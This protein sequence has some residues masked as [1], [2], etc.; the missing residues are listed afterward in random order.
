MKVQNIWINMQGKTRDATWKFCFHRSKQRN[1][2]KRVQRGEHLARQIVT[3]HRLSPSTSQHGHLLAYL[4]MGWIAGGEQ[5]KRSCSCHC[6]PQLG[7]LRSA[8]PAHNCPAT[9]ATIQGRADIVTGERRNRPQPAD[10]TESSL[11]TLCPVSL[12]ISSKHQYQ[13]VPQS[14]KIVVF[15]TFQDA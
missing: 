6:T 9:S 12:T 15:S 8:G 3:H 10:C 2:Q 7:P 11:E 1:D 13:S 5:D 14:P 4:C